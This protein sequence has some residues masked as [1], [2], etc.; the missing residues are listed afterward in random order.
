MTALLFWLAKPI[1]E[2][3]GSIVLLLCL[4]L[5]VAAVVGAAF[6]AA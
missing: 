4:A 3:L 6:A 5:A 1:A 2:F